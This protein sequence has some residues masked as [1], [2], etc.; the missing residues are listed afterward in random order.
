[1]VDG[2]DGSQSS[3]LVAAVTRGTRRRARGGLGPHLKH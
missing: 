1:V 2:H 3:S